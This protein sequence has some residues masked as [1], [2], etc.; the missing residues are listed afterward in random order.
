[1]LPVLLDRFLS[2]SAA[3]AACQ[4]PPAVRPYLIPS[5]FSA[6]TGARIPLAHLSMDPYLPLA[7]RLG[8]GRGAALALPIVAAA[9]AMF[10][11][12]G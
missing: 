9:R 7:M 12:M 6:E 1:G 8:D 11:H 3:L 10:P 5:H 2:Y 4:I